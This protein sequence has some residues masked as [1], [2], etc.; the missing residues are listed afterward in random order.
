MPAL[1]VVIALLL[2]TVAPTASRE[3]TP[4]TLLR[5]AVP[6]AP[7]R[8]GPQAGSALVLLQADVNAEGGVTRVRT[9]RAGAPFTQALREAVSTFRFAPARAAAGARS[10]SVLVA[11]YFR[12]PRLILQEDEAAK[13]RTSDASEALEASVPWPITVIP[14]PYPATAVGDATVVL[15]ALVDERGEVVGAHVIDIPDGAP[16]A[17]FESAALQAV[18]GWR[19]HLPDEGVA[20]FAVVLVLVFS[21]PLD[22]GSR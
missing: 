16:T 3:A 11:G 12:P 14:P 22:I 18:R 20:P 8:A 1:H 10:A 5:A 9:L 17:A 2:A 15:D 4:P 7:E 6:A 13:T 19:F 21:A